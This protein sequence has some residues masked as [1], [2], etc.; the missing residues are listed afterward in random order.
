MRTAH[1]LG[2]RRPTSSRCRSAAA[3]CVPASV[4]PFR[5]L[6]D[7]AVGTCGSDTFSTIRLSAHSNQQV[8]RRRQ[9]PVTQAERQA[10]RH[11]AAPPRPSPS[12]P[13]PATPRTTA[14]ASLVVQARRRTAQRVEGPAASPVSLVAP[15][16]QR[17]TARNGR[18]R[19][20]DDAG[21]RPHQA[22]SLPS[23][24]RSIA[25]GPTAPRAP[26]PE[27]KTDPR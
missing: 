23:M 4:A 5:A 20:A 13:S 24:P 9:K 3:P 2:A 14:S 6:Q 17:H 11:V 25:L 21:P 26:R 27:D 16:T 15:Q 19:S 7:R 8:H 10:H 22:R 12:P 1:L 18:S